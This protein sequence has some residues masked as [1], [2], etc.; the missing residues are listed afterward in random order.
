ML[1]RQRLIVLRIALAAVAIVAVGAALLP[2]AHAASNTHVTVAKRPPT[3]EELRAA[4]DAVEKRAAL[5][6]KTADD[7]EA[8]AASAVANLRQAEA[9]LA[10]LRGLTA[11]HATQQAPAVPQANAAVLAAQSQLRLAQQNAQQ[12]EFTANLTNLRPAAPGA[13]SN[14]LSGIQQMQVQ[15][16]RDALATAQRNLATAQQSAIQVPVITGFSASIDSDAVR[17]ADVAVANARSLAAAAQR[18]AKTAEV[19]AETLAEQADRAR[20]AVEA[21]TQ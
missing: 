3:L 7:D 18:A 4:A 10:A 12:E 5:A 2:A 20:A 19:N 21:A 9:H 16:T 14:V 11:I 15:N 17:I 13:T 6:R 1:R 8:L